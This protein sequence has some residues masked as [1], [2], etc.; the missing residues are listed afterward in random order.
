MTDFQEAN[1]CLVAKNY[2]RTIQLFLRHAE[3]CP[4]DKAIAYA[5]AAECSLRSNVIQTPVSVAPG[6]TLVSQG[7]F[8]TAEYYFRLALQADAKNARALWGLSKLIAESSDER[9]ELLERSVVVQPGTLNLVALAD[10][11]RSHL[12]DL[13]HAYSLYRL[14]QE[15]APRDKTAYLR[16]NDICRRMGRPEE[17]KEWS[18]RWKEANSRKRRVDGKA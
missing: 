3:K 7:D 18:R 9:R 2:P 13:E 17:A 11:Y 12:K 1:R 16:L 6:I 14:A 10:Y 15:H 5:A 8:R 4:A